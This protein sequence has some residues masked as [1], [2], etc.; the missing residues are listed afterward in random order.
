MPVSVPREKAFRMVFTPRRAATFRRTM[1]L[2]WWAAAASGGMASVS[3]LGIQRSARV[4][5]EVSG[6]PSLGIKNGTR[7]RPN[8]LAPVSMST[9][10]SWGS[11]E[12]KTLSTRALI[13]SGSAAMVRIFLWCSSSIVRA[14]PEMRGSSDRSI[15][16]V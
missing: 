9:I 13:R 2:G 7:F 14:I 10:C 6:S 4:R 11:L 16:M 15:C 8:S 1:A 12:A 5:T 3:I